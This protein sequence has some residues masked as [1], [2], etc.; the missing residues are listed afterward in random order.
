MPQADYQVIAY[1]VLD[2]CYCPQHTQSTRHEVSS[3]HFRD[4]QWLRRKPEFPGQ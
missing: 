3:V 2:E 4:R 1:G